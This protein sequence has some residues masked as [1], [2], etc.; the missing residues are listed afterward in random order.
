MKE[1]SA[2]TID[3]RQKFACASDASLFVGWCFVD[4]VDLVGSVGVGSA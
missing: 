3:K 2:I 1:K 4:L